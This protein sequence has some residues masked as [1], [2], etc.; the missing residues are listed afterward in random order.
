MFSTP[1]GGM[2]DG[3]VPAHG[4]AHRREEAIWDAIFTCDA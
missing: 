4:N 1:S 3:M 2:V